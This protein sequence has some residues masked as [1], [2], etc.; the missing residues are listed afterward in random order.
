MVT[1]VVI[2]A[3]VCIFIGIY[4]VFKLKNTGRMMA[5]SA[6]IGWSAVLLAFFETANNFE[7]VL[8]P[9]LEAP[10]VLNQKFWKRHNVQVIRGPYRRPSEVSRDVRVYSM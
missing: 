8:K 5:V 6:V 10:N 4:Q 9:V 7:P 3:F 2:T 1:F